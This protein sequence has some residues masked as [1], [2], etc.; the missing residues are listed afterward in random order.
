[1]R[2]IFF[3]IALIIALGGVQSAFAQ[4]PKVGHTNTGYI[5]TQLP[6]TKKAQTELETVKTQLEKVIQDKSK[7]FQEKVERYQT[8]AASMSQAVRE[9]TET[10]LQKLRAELE[11]LQGKSERTFMEKQESLFKPLLEKVDKAVK[12]VGKEQGYM[13]IINGD[14]GSVG[15]PV[16]LY[17][18]SE[19]TDITNLVLKKLGVIVTK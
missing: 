9:S 13:Y 14:T 12:E 11:E 6:D 15:N 16:L 18:G 4:A 1:M 7:T 8:S 2:K 19:E 3:V 5:L 10:D 17:S